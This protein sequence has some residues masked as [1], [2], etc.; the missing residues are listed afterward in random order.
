MKTRSVLA[1]FMFILAVGSAV[2]SAYFAPMGYSRKTDVT[3][4]ADDCQSRKECPG[5][6]NPCVASV[7]HDGN[8]LT[9]P[10]S[11]TLFNGTPQAGLICGQQLFQQ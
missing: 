2:A 6:S 10:I 1:L 8:P 3:I 5:G 9:A 11:V 7:D 4:Q